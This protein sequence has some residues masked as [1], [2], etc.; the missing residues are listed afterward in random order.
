MFSKKNSILPTYPNIFFQGVTWTTHIFYIWPYRRAVNVRIGLR[1]RAVITKPSLLTYIK[2]G[3]RWRLRQKWPLAQLDSCACT[4]THVSLVSLFVGQRQTLQKQI[5]RH[6][7]RRLN[8]AFTV[9]IW[10]VLSKFGKKEEKIPPNT[11]N[12][13]NRLILLI[14]VRVTKIIRLSPLPNND[15]F[16]TF[17]NKIMYK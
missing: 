1:S 4:L 6:R 11:P 12:I 16:D 3:G 17:A 9:C 8:R 15:T 5:R 10:N 13:G 7:S 2:Y 14:Q